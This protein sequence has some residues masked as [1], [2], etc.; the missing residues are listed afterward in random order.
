MGVYE[1]R[2]GLTTLLSMTGTGSPNTTLSGTFGSSNQGSG[3]FSVSSIRSGST[4][5]IVLGSKPGSTWTA[6]KHEAGVP[7]GSGGSL[8][9]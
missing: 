2:F 1:A 7:A 9:A 3:S 4:T 8:H 6:T 5:C